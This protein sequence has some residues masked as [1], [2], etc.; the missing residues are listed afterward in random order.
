MYMYAIEPTVSISEDVA[1]SVSALSLNF[2]HYTS[3]LRYSVTNATAA[4]VTLNSIELTLANVT[5]FADTFWL[6]GNQPPTFSPGTASTNVILSSGVSIAPGETVD[7]Y[8]PFISA[9]AYNDVNSDYKPENAEG[10]QLK[11]DV[12]TS[13]FYAPIDL[14]QFYAAFGTDFLPGYRYAFNVAITGTDPSFEIKRMKTFDPGVVIGGITWATR[15]V[16]APGTFAGRPES[17]GMF[18]QWNSRVGWSSTDPMVS[19]DGSLWRTSTSTD[20]DWDSANDPCP[21][22]WHVPTNTELQSLIDAGYEWTTK[23]GVSGMA[24]GTAPGTVFMPVANR[25]HSSDGSLQDYGGAFGIYW[26][27]Y[28][29]G[30]EGDGEPKALFLGIANIPPDCFAALDKE[31]PNTGFA[32]RCVAD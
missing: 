19:T 30:D 22:G 18:Y 32:V 13:D 21:A 31:S 1:G 29:Y 23:N 8:R 5:P 20:T 2:Q 3:L 7:F 14:Q 24:F 17:V 6:E 12:N 9:E 4:S 15:N 25:R 27:N 26:G 11:F 10:I 28:T 16:D